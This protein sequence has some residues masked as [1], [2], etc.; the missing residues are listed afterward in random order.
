MKYFWPLFLSS[1][2]VGTAFVYVAAPYARP[3]VAGLFAADPAVPAVADSDARPPAQAET[4]ARAASAP[5]PVP[6]PTLPPPDPDDDTPPAMQGVYPVGRGDRPG[7][8]VTHQRATYYK[9]DGSRMGSVAGGVL[10]DCKE[11]R[12]SSK[13]VVVEGLFFQN[14]ATNGPYLVS[15]KD[16]HLFT[17]S[18]AKLSERQLEALRTYYALSG[19]IGLRK[20]ELLQASAAKNPHFRA[21]NEAYRVFTAHIEKAKVLAAQRDRATELDRSRLD[22]QL[23]EMKVAETRIKSEYEAL[24]LKFREW[25]AQH[26][27]ELAKPENDPDVKRW[28]QEMA[29]LRKTIPGLAL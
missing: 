13:G 5:A 10:F 16:V 6:V 4:D 8:G 27:D 26:A 3:Y 14:G 12:Q 9:L 21:Y 24:H 17:A 18:H 19:K 7:W 11:I 23:R 25:K 2:I 20:T 29:E 15:R 1:L 28:T 22:D